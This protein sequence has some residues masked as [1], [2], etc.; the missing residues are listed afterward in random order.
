MSELLDFPLLACA[1]LSVDLSELADE[2]I[3]LLVECRKI[4]AF[5]VQPQLM[6]HYK[7]LFFS[8]K[9]PQY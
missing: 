4:A 2:L 7:Y 8:L 1:D 3:T 9:S 5:H 6:E